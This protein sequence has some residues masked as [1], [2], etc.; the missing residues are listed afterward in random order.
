MFLFRYELK[1]R[2][3]GPPHASGGVSPFVWSKKQRARS[4]PRE[5]GCF[6]PARTGP[7]RR[8]VLPT[9]VGVFLVLAVD[10]T[11]AESPPHASGGVSDYVQK[12]VPAGKSSPREWGCFLCP[13]RLGHGWRVLP[14]RVGVFL[15]GLEFDLGWTSPPHASGGVS[16]GRKVSPSARESSPR[17]WGCFHVDNARGYPERVLPTRVGVFL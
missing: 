2:F 9:R 8:T 15:L 3:F 14:T 17:E 13:W 10:I 4:S 12:V 7:T 11:L 5:W 6:C 1:E 16:K